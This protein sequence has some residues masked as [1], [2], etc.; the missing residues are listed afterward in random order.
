MS[1]TINIGISACVMGEAVRCDGSH[2]RDSY[3]SDT[4]AKYVKYVPVCPEVAC[5][6]NVPRERVLQEDDGDRI[7][8]VASQSREDWT[9]RMDRSC[10]RLLYDLELSHIDGF[11]L[12]RGTS[13]CALENGQILSPEGAQLRRGM[14]YFTRKMVERMP[15]LPLELS[16]RLKNPIIRENF[17]R[18]V[19]VYRRWRKLLQQERS[20]D[21]LMEFHTRHKML[22]RANDMR[23][24]RQLGKLLGESSAFSDE[25]IHD[26]YGT[27]LFRTLEHNSTPSKNADVLNHA[28][29]YFKKDLDSEDKLHL[30]DMIS[31][32]KNGRTPLLVPMT[33][34]N[35]YA[36]KYDKPYLTQQYFFNPD[37]QEV[38]MLYHV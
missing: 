21:A 8:L 17:V 18:R 2:S 13:S 12:K 4:F 27:L 34:I 29:G 6:M 25:E 14:G 36:R 10:E 38:K 22:I 15:L 3:L 35:H 30:L 20:L 37:P 11:V 23:G 32:Y 19:F 5:G 16:Q 31:S 24:Y 1:E 33:V 9:N 7:R 26:T 28:L